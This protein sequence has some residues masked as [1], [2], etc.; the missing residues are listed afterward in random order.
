MPHHPRGEKTILDKRLKVDRKSHEHGGDRNEKQLKE[1]ET[2][3]HVRFFCRPRISG[4]RLMASA[5]AH[6]E[7]SAIGHP[8]EVGL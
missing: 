3:K 4:F 6:K 2:D 7:L 8:Q 5:S 1:F